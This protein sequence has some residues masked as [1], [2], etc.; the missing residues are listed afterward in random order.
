M[1]NRF[2]LVMAACACAACHGQP[3]PS[4]SGES[5]LAL[6]PEAEA[7]HD[8]L[9]NADIARADAVRRAGLA[10]GFAAALADDAVYLHGGIPIL[11]GREVVKAVIAADSGGYGSAVRWQPVRAEV[12]R[13]RASGFTYGYAFVGRE[14]GREPTLRVDRYIAFWRKG[15]DGWRVV[16]YAETYGAPPA[17][18]TVPSTAMDGVLADVAMSPTRAPVDRLRAAD[19]AF[20]HDADRLGAGEAFGRYAAADAQIFS[21][22]GEFITGPEA[23][24]ASFGPSAGNSSFTWQPILAEMSAAGDMGF[25]VGNATVTVEREDGNAVVRYSKYLTVWK[26]QRDGAWKYVVDGGNARPSPRANVPV[27]P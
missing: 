19:V 15:N 14:A 17:P 12:S 11:R 22:A 9:L 1:R 18:L 23:I 21:A 5:L 7:A 24:T 26:R 16:A 2:M 3:G 27:R 6:P 10:E 8:A 13:D 4:F 25:T 20:S